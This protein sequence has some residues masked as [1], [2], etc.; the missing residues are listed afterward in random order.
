MIRQPFHGELE[1]RVG[2]QVVGVVAVFIA[3]G[4][5]KPDDLVQPMRDPLRRA[6]VGDAIRQSCSQARAPLDLAQSQKATVRGHQRGI[7]PRLDR[8]AVDR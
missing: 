6:R 3:G 2:A 5:A 1:Q 7:K 4:D 8:P